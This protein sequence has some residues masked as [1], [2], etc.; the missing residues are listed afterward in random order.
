MSKLL[1]ALLLLSTTAY[2]D[3]WES[4]NKIGGKIVLTDTK[5]T[6]EPT[7][8]V[9]FSQSNEGPTLFGCWFYAEGYIMVTWNDGDIRSYPSD[10]FTK[11][12]N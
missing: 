6:S 3:S 7:K 12:Q 2:A 11:K 1:I 8:M 10:T 9:I 4:P 5:C